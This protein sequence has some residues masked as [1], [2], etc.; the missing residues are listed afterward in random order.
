M[1]C[2]VSWARA[3][4]AGAALNERIRRGPCTAEVAIVSTVGIE[5]QAMVTVRP[6]R[7]R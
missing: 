6:A 5:P 4:W 3:A 2:S 1:T 7:R